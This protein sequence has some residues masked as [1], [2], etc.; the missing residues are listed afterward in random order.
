MHYGHQHGWHWWYTVID[1]SNHTHNGTETDPKLLVSPKY[2]LK[3]NQVFA[4]RNRH[5]SNVVHTIPKAFL[6]GSV[7]QLKLNTQARLYFNKSC[8]EINTN[9]WFTPIVKLALCEV[10]QQRGLSHST[11]SKQDHSKLVVENRLYHAVLV[12]IICYKYEHTKVVTSINSNNPHEEWLK[13]ALNDRKSCLYAFNKR[14]YQQRQNWRII[15]IRKLK[16]CTGQDHHISNDQLTNT[17]P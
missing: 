9:S 6:S 8:K 11:V 7:P 13:C 17:T 1:H 3:L 14:C 5:S 4:S 2:R 15:N 12:H 10:L 16:S